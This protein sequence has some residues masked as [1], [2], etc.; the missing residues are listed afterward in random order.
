VVSGQPQLCGPSRPPAYPDES[1]RN[2]E[3]GT[4]VLRVTVMQMGPPA[5]VL[6][7]RSSGHPALD[8]AAMRAVR[9]WC[10]MPVLEGGAP[11]LSSRPVPVTFR[12]QGES[13]W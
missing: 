5:A 11:M 9:D 3:Q 2:A 7:E 10:F 6:V 4:V 8:E 13:L 1:R 12:L